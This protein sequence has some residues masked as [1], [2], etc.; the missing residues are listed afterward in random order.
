MAAVAGLFMAT[1]C[2]KSYDCTCTDLVGNPTGD[3]TE[4]GSDANDACDKAEDKILG[5]PTEI[6]TPK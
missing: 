3:K 1:S 4:K 6:C 2:K 5:I